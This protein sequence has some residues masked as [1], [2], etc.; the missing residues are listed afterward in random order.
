MVSL[1]KDVVFNKHERLECV[2]YISK[3]RLAHCS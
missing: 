2:H 3:V 1:S